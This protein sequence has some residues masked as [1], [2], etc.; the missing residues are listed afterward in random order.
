MRLFTEHPHQQGISYMEHAR[1]AIGIAYRLVSSAIVFALHAIV[2]AVRIE[3]RL[4]LE[5]TIDFLD[6]RNWW[7]ENSKKVNLGISSEPLTVSGVHKL[8]KNEQAAF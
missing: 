4:D 3:P 7:I 6:E 1:F 8:Q 2:P 5:A